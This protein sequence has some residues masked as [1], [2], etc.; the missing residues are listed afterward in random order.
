MHDGALAAL[1]FN[2]DGAKAIDAA[3]P[4]AGPVEANLH[5]E[6]VVGKTR[7]RLASFVVC[8]GF[9]LFG[10]N[11]KRLPNDDLYVHFS[12]GKE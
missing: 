8:E 5:A 10:G 2:R 7:Q 3:F 1:R 6:N 11:G 9:D 12:G 4:H